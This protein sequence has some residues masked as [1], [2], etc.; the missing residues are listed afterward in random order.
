MATRIEKGFFDLNR[1]I[2]AE[3]YLTAME[4][5]Y[6]VFE[7]D[8]EEAALDAVHLEAEQEIGR[9]R[10]QSIEIDERINEDTFKVRATYEPLVYETDGDTPEMEPSFAFDTGGGSRHIMQS[11]KTTNKYPSS[12][13]DFGGA[14]G[15]D[16][17]GNVNG[18]DVTIPTMNFTETHYMR[19]SKVSTRYKQT[20]ADLT[21][22]VN[23]SKF[24]GYDAGEVLFLGASG[25]RRGKRSD[26][27]WE[28][29]FKFAVSVNVKNMKVGDLTVSK[30]DGWDYL[31]VR[32]HND[33]SDDQKNLIKKPVGAYVEQV[34]E[35][36]NFGA[37][38]I[39]R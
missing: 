2:N 34:Y 24:K 36:K 4:V 3:G 14:I 19:P 39:G 18:V 25:S 10:L 11:L 27:Y 30:K 8:D 35:A 22:S 26:D 7:V 15:V 37:L 33:V 20:I 21:G 6:I 32:Y 12:S 23:N 17:E 9:L 28:I 5:P 13:P 1:S 31:W 38:G 29:T 16:N